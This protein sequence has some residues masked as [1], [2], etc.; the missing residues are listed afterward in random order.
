[1]KQLFFIFFLL[2]IVSCKQEVTNPDFLIGKWKRV[3]NENSKE[4]FEIW[5]QNFSG[6]GYSLQEKDTVFKENLAIIEIQGNKYLQVTG[7]NQRPTLFEFTEL[8]KNSFTCKNP[9][10][11]F[12]KLISYWL[13]NNQLK[14]KVAN[15]DF[16]IDFV[17][18]RI[19]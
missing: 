15:D 10:N 1:M 9:S 8:T 3:N 12:P 2:I 4:T 6:I 19:K 13:E 14:A 18:D 17:F 16:A 5:N 7:V 11:E